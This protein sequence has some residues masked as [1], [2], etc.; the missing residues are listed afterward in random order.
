MQFSQRKLM[1]KIFFFFVRAAEYPIYIP[2]VREIPYSFR[3]TKCVVASLTRVFVTRYKVN[4][5]IPIHFRFGF[6][7]PQRFAEQERPDRLASHREA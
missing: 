1:G 2:L 6:L 4:E 7:A 3:F 5:V